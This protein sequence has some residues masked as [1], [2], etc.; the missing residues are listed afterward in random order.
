MPRDDATHGDA[1]G[2]RA[3]AS[4]RQQVVGNCRKQPTEANASPVISETEL[5]S[6]EPPE[7]VTRRQSWTISTGRNKTFSSDHAMSWSIENAVEAMSG[8]AF[9]LT[10]GNAAPVIDKARLLAHLKVVTQLFDTD[11]GKDFEFPPEVFTRDQAVMDATGSLSAV[12][13]AVQRQGLLGRT[14]QRR[15]SRAVHHEVVCPV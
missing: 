3:E 14:V 8:D 15:Q 5:Q 11:Q 6:E 13:E 1:E 2:T 10:R 9:I 12:V 4:E 7:T